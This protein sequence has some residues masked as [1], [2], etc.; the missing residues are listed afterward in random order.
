MLESR[1]IY[2][3]LDWCL[4]FLFIKV[5]ILEKGRSNASS[6]LVMIKNRVG[7]SVNYL[8]ISGL[9]ARRYPI[10]C[11]LSQFLSRHYL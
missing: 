9:I 4:V 7:S 1:L 11:R 6:F 3:V 8:N 2:Q 5:Y 10:R